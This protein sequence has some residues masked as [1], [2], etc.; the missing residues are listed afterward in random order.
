VALASVV[1]MAREGRDVPAVGV[2]VRKS[3][4]RFVLASTARRALR[5]EEEVA[6]WLAVALEEWAAVGSAL[7]VAAFEAAGVV[8]DWGWVLKDERR[9]IEASSLLF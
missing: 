8:V 9:V 1:D 5:F 3:A 7:E 2:S 4:F 6:G